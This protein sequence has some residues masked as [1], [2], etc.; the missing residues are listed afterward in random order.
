MDTEVRMEIIP[1]KV[2]YERFLPPI[3]AKGVKQGGLNNFQTLAFGNFATFLSK[4]ALLEIT[5]FSLPYTMAVVI[6]YY[7]PS[8][9]K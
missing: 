5:I 2:H 9:L 8:C 6:P 1:K 4:G 7:S 3:E